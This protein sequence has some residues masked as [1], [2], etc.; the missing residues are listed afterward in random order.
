MS[1][2]EALG[3]C[4]TILDLRALDRSLLRPRPPPAQNKNLYAH[5][6]KSWISPVTEGTYLNI[7][8]MMKSPEK[9]DS[10]GHLHT[11]AQLRVAELSRTCRPGKNML[12]RISKNLKHK[13]ESSVTYILAAIFFLDRLICTNHKPTF[14]KSGF[15]MIPVFWGS[16]FGF[17]MVTVLTCFLL[18]SA[19]ISSLAALSS[20]VTVLKSVDKLKIGLKKMTRI[21]KV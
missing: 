13:A 7:L 21:K 1:W 18:V 5:T 14:K 11:W 9:G 3:L 10:S 17:Q 4:N 15:Q 8:D 2:S 19:S 16:N 20:F 12:N 6:C